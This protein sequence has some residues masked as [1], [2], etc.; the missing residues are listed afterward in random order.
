MADKQHYDVHWSKWPD[1]LAPDREK[2]FKRMGE[3]LVFRDAAERNYQEPEKYFAAIYWLGKQADKRDKRIDLTLRIAQ[4]TL[5]VAS[6]TLSRVDPF[7]LYARLAPR[8]TRN[9]RPGRRIRIFP[10]APA[11]EQMGSE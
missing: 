2:H 11:S 8:R 3:K 1:Y 7:Y 9:H 4:L 5:L 6:L 10:Y